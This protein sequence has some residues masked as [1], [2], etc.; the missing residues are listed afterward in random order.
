LKNPLGTMKRL[1]HAL[2]LQAYKAYCYGYSDGR[3]GKAFLGF[4]EFCQRIK[5]VVK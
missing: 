1:Q 2:T 3:D 5:E 4:R